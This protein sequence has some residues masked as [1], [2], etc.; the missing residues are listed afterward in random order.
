[1]IEWGAV[2]KSASML[3]PKHMVP[4]GWKHCQLSY[5]EQEGLQQMPKDRGSE[6]GDVDGRWNTV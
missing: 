3:L 4:A 6:Q 5:V 2:R 1:M